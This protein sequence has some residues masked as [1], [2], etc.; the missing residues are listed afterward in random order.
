VSLIYSML[1]S[2]DGYVEDEHGIRSPDLA[3]VSEMQIEPQLEV[4]F[5]KALKR[6]NMLTEG[7]K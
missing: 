7:T 5:P 1:M 4:S 3:L 6:I 2:L